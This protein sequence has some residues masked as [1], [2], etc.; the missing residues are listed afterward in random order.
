VKETLICNYNVTSPDF[1]VTKIDHTFL[2][3]GHSYLPCDQDFGLIVKQK[4]YFPEICVPDHWMTVIKAARKVKPFHIILLTSEDT[5]STTT[6]E[7]WIIN[8]KNSR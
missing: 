7:N 4:R 8:I 2:I 6:L 1:E 5:K 3:S